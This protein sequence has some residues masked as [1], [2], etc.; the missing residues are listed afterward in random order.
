MLRALGLRALS[1]ILSLLVASVV[2]FVML[3]AVPG[4]PAAFMLGLN[5]QPETVAALRADLGLEGP[6]PARYLDWIGGMRTA[7]SD[8]SAGSSGVTESASSEG[9]TNTPR[10]A[11]EAS[12]ETAVAAEWNAMRARLYDAVALGT[13]GSFADG[14]SVAQNV[15]ARFEDA[16]G[17]WGAHEQLEATTT[18]SSSR[19]SAAGP[20]RGRRRRSTSS[21]SGRA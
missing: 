13:A 7:G 2:I 3:Q 4:D 14:A 15:F 18:S 19:P 9:S 6:L 10:P 16:S 20:T 5:A 17:E 1:L 12:A 11:P 21:C 8:G